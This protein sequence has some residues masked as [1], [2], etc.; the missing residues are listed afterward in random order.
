MP[1]L[2]VVSGAEVVRALERL[3]FTVVASAWWLPRWRDWARIRCRVGKAIACPPGGAP[4]PLND[5]H[6]ALCP[7]YDEHRSGG[8]QR[9]L[10]QH[11]ERG[12]QRGQRRRRGLTPIPA[13]PLKG[14]G[15]T[16]KWL[17]TGRNTHHP[18]PSPRAGGRLGGGSNPARGYGARGHG[19]R[20]H[21]LGRELSP[22]SRPSPSRGKEEEGR[23]L[24]PAG[25][26]GRAALENMAKPRARSSAHNKIAVCQFLERK[27]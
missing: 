22:P 7:S 13:F 11:L 16:G 4:N 19:P 1:K 18:S 5:G 9:I 10:S 12:S 2:P 14:E 6:A 21:S 8:D 27:V 15:G 20:R 24:G 23:P 17:R 3:G 25:L 26:R